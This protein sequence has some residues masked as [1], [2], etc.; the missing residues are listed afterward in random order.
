MRA[1]LHRFFGAGEVERAV[2][3]RDVGKCGRELYFW[4]FV[5]AGLHILDILAD[6]APEIRQRAYGRNRARRECGLMRVLDRKSGRRRPCWSPAP[7]RAT[8]SYSSLSSSSSM[9]SE[10]ALPGSQCRD[11]TARQR[12]TGPAEIH[13]Q[14]SRGAP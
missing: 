6:D 12:S 9:L 4:S 7:V 8:G 14:V 10:G 3:Q 11:A 2:D 13:D 5:V 1:L